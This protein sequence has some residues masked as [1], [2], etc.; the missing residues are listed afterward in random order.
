MKK[1]SKSKPRRLASHKETVAR[2][3]KK[4]RLHFAKLNG[5]KQSGRPRCSK[6]HKEIV[7]Q[8][9]EENRAYFAEL[10]RNKSSTETVAPIRVEKIRDEN[11]A[12]DLEVLKKVPLEF[13]TTAKLFHICPHC[14]GKIT[15][16]AESRGLVSQCPDCKHLI[17]LGRTSSTTVLRSSDSFAPLFPEA[18]TRR[19]YHF[20]SVSINFAIALV[21]CFMGFIMLVVLVCRSVVAIKADRNLA[22][23]MVQQRTEKKSQPTPV[24]IPIYASSSS[25]KWTPGPSADGNTWN[26]QSDDAKWDL[27]TRL[28]AQSK[29]GV[30]AQTFYLGLDTAYN[31]S[32][33]QALNTPITLAAQNIEESRNPGHYK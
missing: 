7:A 1:P 17:I 11:P 31:P 3:T 19:N 21:L 2:I 25:S 6:S 14:K 12:L 24:A 10:D 33:A 5:S 26:S 15:Y 18:G 4:N 30:S 23:A 13:G 27:A 20:S 32:D 29:Y 8:I 16:V 22:A 28:A 9:T